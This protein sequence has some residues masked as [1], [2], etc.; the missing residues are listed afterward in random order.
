[1]WAGDWRL[2]VIQ[3]QTWQLPQEWEWPQCLHTR[4]WTGPA[5][6]TACPLPCTPRSREWAED[7][8]IKRIFHQGA[9]PVAGGLQR[10]DYRVVNKHFDTY[11]DTMIYI[12]CTTM[13]HVYSIYHTPSHIS[14]C[15]QDNFN[16]GPNF[17]F[18]P[19]GEVHKAQGPSWPD[20]SHSL[21]PRPGNIWA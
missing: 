13:Y 16:F 9:R 10:C 21:Q 2:T 8:D 6:A 12:P 7:R 11:L 5:W 19:D 20:I 17:P 4:W 15:Q 1:M 14:T 18:F 3:V